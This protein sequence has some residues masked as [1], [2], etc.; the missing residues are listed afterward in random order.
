[1]L[2]ADEHRLRYIMDD[3]PLLERMS[4]VDDFTDSSDP[5][6]D[7]SDTDSSSTDTTEP[8]EL[9]CTLCLQK[10]TV[11]NRIVVCE[12][13]EKPFHV[14][15]YR[16]HLVCWPCPH[17]R[18]HFPLCDKIEERHP[19][20]MW[21][22]QRDAGLLSPE[23]EDDPPERFLGHVFC[24]VDTARTPD[25]TAH[26]CDYFRYVFIF[27][28]L[29]FDLFGDSATD[30][31]Y[32]TFAVRFALFVWVLVSWESGLDYARCDGGMARTPQARWIGLFI[33]ELIPYGRGGS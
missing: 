33:L 12:H 3:D 1:M 26:Y 15:H 28:Y 10:F 25:R 29:P 2:P 11:G 9:L 19:F 20:E 4:F 8:E 5:G 23:E 27:L 30:G 22:G 21:R 32:D 7:T 24:S 17:D 16:A 13:C 6:D 14:I 31:L 18:W